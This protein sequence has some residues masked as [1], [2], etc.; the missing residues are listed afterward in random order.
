MKF[1]TTAKR[2]KQALQIVEAALP[3]RTTLPAATHVKISASG[4]TITLTTTNLHLMIQYTF[5]ADIKKEGVAVVPAKRLL[6]FSKTLS[7]EEL[8]AKL[9]GKFLEIT[10]GKAL[11]EMPVL[12][13]QEFPEVAHVTGQ[14]FTVKQTDLREALRLTSFAAEQ[15]TDRYILNGCYLSFTP[16]DQ[17]SILATD[18]RRLAQYT[19]SV[20]SM[21]KKP[22][23]VKF[24]FPQGAAKLLQSHLEHEVDTVVT[25]GERHVSVSFTAP[26]G[27]SYYMSF[28]QVEGQYPDCKALIPAATNANKVDRQNL[29]MALKRAIA[30]VDADGRVHLKFRAGSIDIEASGTGASA[31]GRVLEPVT[32]EYS[33]K[34]IDAT[35][36]PKYLV[37]V[38]DELKD[39]TIEFDITGTE[40]PMIFTSKGY[41]YLNMPLRA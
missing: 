26:A 3:T 36:T 28:N 39:E 11:L 34:P 40:R 41:I 32:A 8:S 38:L 20:V 10:A 7:S 37:E 21:P 33:G 14:A 6:D 13:D 22:D 15:N 5:E 19:F 17:C 30:A 4:K 31:S 18:S 29:L 35:F 16:T 23:A 25:Q 24:L 1:T 2:L 27:D 12:P 9:E